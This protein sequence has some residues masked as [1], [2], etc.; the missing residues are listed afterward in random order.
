MLRVVLMV[1]MVQPVPPLLLLLLRVARV[2]VVR[3]R[4]VRVRRSRCRV[5]AASD[6]DAM[7]E[8]GAWR[9]PPSTPGARAGPRGTRSK[10]FGGASGSSWLG[11]RGGWC[12]GRGR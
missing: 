7:A 10:C 3:V 11:R 6:V 12:W 4:V 8:H 1:F 2:R 9:M 5:D